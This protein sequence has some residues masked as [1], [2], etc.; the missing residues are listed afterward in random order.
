MFFS[1]IL[2]TS[3]TTNDIKPKTFTKPVYINS[4]GNALIILIKFNIRVIIVGHRKFFIYNGR[5]S[6]VFLLV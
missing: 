5:H 3:I 6:L 1:L 4:F 2:L